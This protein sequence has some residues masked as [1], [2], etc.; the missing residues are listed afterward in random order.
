MVAD[1]E[2]AL[3]DLKTFSAERCRGALHSNLLVAEPLAACMSPAV[4]RPVG[5]MPLGAHKP[6]G[7]F[8]EP[9]QAP[10][11]LE[12]VDP[13]PVTERRSR[14]WIDFLTTNWTTNVVTLYH[15]YHLLRPILVDV[16][17]TNVRDG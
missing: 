4:A 8:S 2:L 9:L 3:A 6:L 17:E 5:V 15:W 16:P 11:A 13:I 10:A 12:E 7:I 1:L 14:G